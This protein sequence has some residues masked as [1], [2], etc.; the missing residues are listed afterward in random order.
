M[1]DLSTSLRANILQFT[2]SPDVNTWGLDDLEEADDELHRPE[3][4]GSDKIYRDGHFMSLRGLSNLG[5][6]ILLIVGIIVL[7]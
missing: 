4:L 2:L 5:C 7:L 1:H 3:P 6:L